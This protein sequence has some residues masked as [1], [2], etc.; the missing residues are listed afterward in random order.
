[1]TRGWC[2]AW[3][4]CLFTSQISPV[5]LPNYTLLGARGCEQLAQS[6]Y[7]AAP[8][9]GIELSAC[10]TTPPIDQA[11]RT[12]IQIEN[13]NSMNFKIRRIH[14]FYMLMNFNKKT[15]F[16]VLKITDRIE[17][18][19]A[20]ILTQ[21]AEKENSIVMSAEPTLARWYTCATKCR[22]QSSNTKCKT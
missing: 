9:S 19:D 17:I 11:Y 18:F 8:W 2:I 3:C 12:L 14:E 5:G 16:V 1:M 6:C 21:S 15:K 13:A 22:F 4:M 7:A 10:T 20:I